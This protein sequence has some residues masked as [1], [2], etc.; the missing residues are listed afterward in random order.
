[1]SPVDGDQRWHYREYP[2]AGFGLNVVA[3]LV[4]TLSG[5]SFP[6]GDS[7]LSTS[8][9]TSVPPNIVITVITVINV[10]SQWLQGFQVLTMSG[11]GLWLKAE[12]TIDEIQ[13]GLSSAFCSRVHF[14]S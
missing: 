5:I 10:L 8:Y 13:V 3:H 7:L 2:A 6:V 9:K 4:R 11:L 1:M 12:I 14:F